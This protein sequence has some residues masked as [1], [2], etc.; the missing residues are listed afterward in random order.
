MGQRGGASRSPP[1]EAV[2]RDA[3]ASTRIASQTT[4]PP[5]TRLVATKACPSFTLV[6][7][8]YTAVKSRKINARILN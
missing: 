8:L 4:D 5:K 1:G 3:N 2:V 6:L 7:I